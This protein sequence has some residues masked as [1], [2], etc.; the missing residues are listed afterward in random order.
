[1]GFLLSSR[2]GEPFVMSYSS[3]RGVLCTGVL[4]CT[5]SA[6]VVPVFSAETNPS[7]NAM[8]RSRED[9]SAA[10]TLA[11]QAVQQLQ[12]QQ[13]A[14]LQAVQDAREQAEAASRRNEQRVESLRHLLFALFVIVGTVTLG[15]AWYIRSLLQALRGRDQSPPLFE[16]ARY[17]SPH[18][19]DNASRV[20]ALL[21]RGQTLLEQRNPLE[22]LA[23]FE[24]AIAADAPT[25][26]AFIK[27]ATAL[28]R[29]GRLD[30]ALAGY[31]H[32]LALDASHADA[33]I[34][35]GNV[36]NR[37][38]RYQEALACFEQAAD[39]QHHLHALPH[40]VHGPA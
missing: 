36:L 34:G 28:E 14:T 13:R 16:R 35:K 1:M 26:N 33:Y 5:L 27:K 15:A 9:K 40:V 8:T 2:L 37:L 7:T 30:E 10:F 11:L 23:C 38:E 22:A 6:C 20:A 4:A 39:Y 24:K 29:L 31:E 21:G 25:A 18:S 32:A 17:S 12:A 3:C 19:P